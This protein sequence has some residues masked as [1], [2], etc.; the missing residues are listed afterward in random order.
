[1]PSLLPRE[2]GYMITGGGDDAGRDEALPICSNYSVEA[3]R[4]HWR[5]VIPV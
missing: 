5:L 4:V 1:M 3:S 2:A